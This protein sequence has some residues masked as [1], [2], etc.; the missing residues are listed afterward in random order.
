LSA[1]KEEDLL[2]RTSSEKRGEKVKERFAGKYRQGIWQEKGA[3]GSGKGGKKI[4]VCG[5]DPSR[6][7]KGKCHPVKKRGRNFPLTTIAKRKKK[8]Q[9]KKDRKKVN[10]IKKDLRGKRGKRPM[11][12]VKGE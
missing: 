7:E 9:T 10:A 1:G 5:A 6:K 4:N 3:R 2:D 8:L 12:N 11:N